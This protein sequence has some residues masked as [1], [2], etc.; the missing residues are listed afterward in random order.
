MHH[1]KEHKCRKAEIVIID[2]NKQGKCYVTHD[3]PNC[4]HIFVAY[5]DVC[6][7]RDDSREDHQRLLVPPLVEEAHN[8]V[9]KQQRTDYVLRQ[10]NQG[11]PRKH[12]QIQQDTPLSTH[13]RRKNDVTTTANRRRIRHEE[14]FCQ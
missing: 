6:R 10:E 3:R 9:D 2:E 5:A 12:Q 11:N 14:S 8:F 1:F 13:P 7:R 4:S